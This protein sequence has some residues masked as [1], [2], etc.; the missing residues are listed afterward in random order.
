[1]DVFPLFHSLKKPKFSSKLLLN[2]DIICKFALSIR[3]AG[4]VAHYG[5]EALLGVIAQTTVPTGGYWFDGSTDK[6]I[7]VDENDEVSVMAGQGFFLLPAALGSES[8]DAL[9]GTASTKGDVNGD[10]EV[11]IGDIVAVTNVMAGIT[12]DTNIVA[13]ADVNGDGEV[14]IGDIVAITNIMAGRE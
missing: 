9:F 6:L 4:I 5:V 14:G 8:L 11:G 13:C 2:S 10:G 1:M 3:T 12:T 7:R